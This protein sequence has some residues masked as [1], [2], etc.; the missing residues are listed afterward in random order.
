MALLSLAIWFDFVIVEVTLYF[1]A[2]LVA[3]TYDQADYEQSC[4]D[5]D[6]HH[7]GDNLSMIVHFHF[8]LLRVLLRLLGRH[9]LLWLP[10]FRAAIARQLPLLSCSHRYWSWVRLSRSI[11][12]GG[13]FL[14]DN[15]ASF[16]IMAITTDVL[17][18]L[19]FLRKKTADG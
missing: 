16:F 17:Y 6:Y 13:H 10:C 4:Y 3:L 18:Y 7:C 1:T 15:V 9:S 2:L 11:V 5:P 14:S 19:F 12:A 8:S